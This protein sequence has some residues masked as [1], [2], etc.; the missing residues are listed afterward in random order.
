MS[1]S[2]GHN[3]AN[4]NAMTSIVPE[5]ERDEAWQLIITLFGLEQLTQAFRAIFLKSNLHAHESRG[6]RARLW[7]HTENGR[8]QTN[9]YTVGA[10]GR[11]GRRSA[12]LPYRKDHH[13]GGWSAAQ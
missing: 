3:P 9:S 6:T 12:D 8:K 7:T 11:S 5:V 13:E 1:D 2:M 4:L 10:Y